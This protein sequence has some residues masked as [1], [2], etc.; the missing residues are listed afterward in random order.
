M[1]LDWVEGLG[2]QHDKKRL[3]AMAAETRTILQQ[4]YDYK[5]IDVD[6]KLTLQVIPTGT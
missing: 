2:A 6:K 4:T 1:Q 5:G 3:R